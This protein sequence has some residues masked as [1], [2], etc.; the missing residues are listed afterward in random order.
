M[1]AHGTSQRLS[2]TASAWFLRPSFRVILASRHA[3]TN[4]NCN[5]FLQPK[6]YKHPKVVPLLSAILATLMLN[7]GKA[8]FKNLELMQGNTLN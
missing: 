6:E 4:K 2:R 8:D 3:L 1:H 5:S 7:Q